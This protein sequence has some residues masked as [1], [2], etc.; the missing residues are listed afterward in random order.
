M[1]L[2]QNRHPSEKR[3]KYDLCAIYRRSPGGENTFLPYLGYKDRYQIQY[4]TDDC[5]NVSSKYLTYAYV[6]SNGW[7]VSGIRASDCVA[8]GEC[9]CKSYGTEEFD[10]F[11]NV[12]G[13]SSARL[14]SECRNGT[15]RVNQAQASD[16]GIDAGIRVQIR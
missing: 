3:R 16:A 15:H 4:T 7:S 12:C 10:D 11:S 1:C 6:R 9:A 13:E 2:R 8:T 14:F 5:A